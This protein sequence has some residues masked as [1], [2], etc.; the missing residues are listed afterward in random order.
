MSDKDPY[1][2][3]DNSTVSNWEGQEVNKDMDL[4]DKLVE[5]EGGDLE[6]AE[7]RFEKESAGAE[8][9]PGEVKRK[10]GEGFV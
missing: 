7:K 4:V 8:P 1:T 6:A 2:E 10:N 3:P 9:G 5:E